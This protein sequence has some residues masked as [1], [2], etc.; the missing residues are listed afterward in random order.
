ML[1]FTGWYFV[2]ILNFLALVFILNIILFKPFL[3]LF[4]ERDNSIGG[5]LNAAKDMDKKREENLSM[6]QHELREARNKSKEIFESMRREGLNKQKEMLEEA[7]HKARGLIERAREELRSEVERARQ[8]L[9]ADVD[10]FSDEI[11]N[12]LVGI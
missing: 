8:K 11:V 3:K 2:L 4:K 5:A 1:D 12:K 6:M 9:R 7:N 10:K